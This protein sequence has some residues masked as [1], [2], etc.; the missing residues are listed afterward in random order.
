MLGDNAKIGMLMVGLGVLF[1]FLGVLLLFD[2][3]LLAIGNV[4]FLAGIP[5]LIGWRQAA[6][7]FDPRR[8]G[9]ARGVICFFAGVLL[10]LRRWAVVGMIVEVIGMVEMFG[11]FLPLVVASLRGLPYIGPVLSAPGVAA[12]IDRLSGARDKRP[13]V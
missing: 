6:R 5:F 13:P 3:G 1:L 11:T 4:L 10:V 8:K 12:V 2:S 7:F 9:K